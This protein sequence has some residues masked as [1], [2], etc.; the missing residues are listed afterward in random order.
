MICDIELA[1]KDKVGC[2]SYVRGYDAVKKKVAE[3]S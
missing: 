2:A 1:S 3:V